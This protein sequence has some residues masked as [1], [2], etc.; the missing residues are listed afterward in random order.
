[1]EIVATQDSDE[2]QFPLASENL[3]WDQELDLAVGR[4]LLYKELLGQEKS[5]DGGET[6]C[7]AAVQFVYRMLKEL[8]DN[9]SEGILV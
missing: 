6:I 7:E 1:M 9:S 8:S 4:E 2:T 3:I 5:P